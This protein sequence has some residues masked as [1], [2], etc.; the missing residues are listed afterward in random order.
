MLILRYYL[1]VAPNVLCGIALLLAVR[2]QSFK[3]LPVFVILLGFNVL[4]FLVALT[5]PFFYPQAV[6][7][8]CVV[9]G[10]NRDSNFNQGKYS[11]IGLWRSSLPSSRS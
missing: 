6:Y 5:V 1:L 11:R 10:A 4:Q 8:W 2:K 9:I 3:T 7:K